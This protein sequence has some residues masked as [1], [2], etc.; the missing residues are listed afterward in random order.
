M[1]RSKSDVY[2]HRGWRYA[3]VQCVGLI[4]VALFVEG[5]RQIYQP[6]ALMVSGALIVVWTVLKV[7]S[8][9]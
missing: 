7:R 5:V 9:S 2:L 3:L 1:Q 4:G 8:M 6:A